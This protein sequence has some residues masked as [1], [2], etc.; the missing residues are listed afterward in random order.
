MSNTKRTSHLGKINSAST[1]QLTDASLLQYSPVQYWTFV[2]ATGARGKSVEMCCEEE[3]I[4]LAQMMI[5]ALYEVVVRS[6]NEQIQ[7]VFADGEL[8]EGASTV[9]NF[10]IVQ[11][12]RRQQVESDVKEYA[13]LAT[14]TS[15][16][17]SYRFT[18]KS[19]SDEQVLLH[20]V[21]VGSNF[22]S[23]VAN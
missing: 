17:K 6:N 23:L 13:V 22:M 1:Y 5:A 18:Y 21:V 15:S 7:K 11:A 10:R 12:E 19:I 8:Q 14:V 20:C 3:K 4:W 2:A 16:P 9:R